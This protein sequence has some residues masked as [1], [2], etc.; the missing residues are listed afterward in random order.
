MNSD[1]A[2][3][4]ATRD[5]RNHLNMTNYTTFQAIL[6]QKDS[7]S[8][9]W[10]IE[11]IHLKIGTSAYSNSELENLQFWIEI[12]NDANLKVSYVELEYCSSTFHI[13]KTRNSNLEI[14][15]F[16]FK[17]TNSDRILNW[18]M[19]IFKHLDGCSH[20]ARFIR[21][22]GENNLGLKMIELEISKSRNIAQ[23]SKSLMAQWT[24]KVIYRTLF[25]K[26]DMAGR[27][28]G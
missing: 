20:C 7:K 26:F 19:P 18:N 15:I 13:K 23:N 27:G 3:A 28:S 9:Y 6:I 21:W 24:E 16:Q 17:I 12:F 1:K 10:H 14:G 8:E 2:V 11:S 25:N 5:W 4:S 22:I